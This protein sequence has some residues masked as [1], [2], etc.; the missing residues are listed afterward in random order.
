MALGIAVVWRR[1]SANPPPAQAGGFAVTVLLVS[2]LIHA[3]VMPII[4]FIPAS[5]ILFVIAAR[6]MGS[7][8]LLFDALVGVIG[9]TTL[10]FVFTRGLGLAL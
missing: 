2:L 4:G 7:H 3:V 5:A 10:F 1:A 9:A 8:R 6:L